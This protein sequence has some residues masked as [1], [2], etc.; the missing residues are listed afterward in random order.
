M[1]TPDTLLDQFIAGRPAPFATAGE[2]PWKEA[3]AVALASSPPSAEGSFLELDFAVAPAIGYA[4]GAD[5]DNFCEPVFSVLANRLGW[6]G[7]RRPNIQAFRARKTLAEPAGC[8]IRISIARW[9]DSWIEG[10]SLLD[11]VSVGPLPRGARDEAFATWVEATMVRAADPEAV[12]AVDLGFSGPVNLG[13][14]ATGRLKNVIDCLYPVLGGRPGAPNDA[15][16][17]QPCGGTH[18]PRRRRR[19]SRSGRRATT[20]RSALRPE[21]LRSWSQAPSR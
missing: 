12:L 5:L 11:A 3:I 21:G 8:R 13:G 4:R 19:G 10:L 14:I 16:I 6:F 17:C 1:Q 18:G 7:G 15:R 9:R 20:E 2:R